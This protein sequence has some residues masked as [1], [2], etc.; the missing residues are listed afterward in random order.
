MRRIALYFVL[1]IAVLLG[2]LYGALT[3]VPAERITALVAGPVER[4][5]GLNVRLSGRLSP[6]LYPAIGVR[7][8]PI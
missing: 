4:A 7:T 5:T 8:G 3:L 2:A 1:F 6:T